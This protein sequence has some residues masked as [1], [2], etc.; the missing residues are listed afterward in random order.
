MEGI[1]SDPKDLCHQKL[2]HNFLGLALK[3]FYTVPYYC[4]E[5][6][7][8]AILFAILENSN[9]VVLVDCVCQ[10]HFKKGFAFIEK[11]YVLVYCL[12]DHQYYPIYLLLTFHCYNYYYYYYVITVVIRE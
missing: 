11:G 4:S 6:N 10:V 3:S 9:H 8:S 1:K 5:T 12:L 7:L 2:L